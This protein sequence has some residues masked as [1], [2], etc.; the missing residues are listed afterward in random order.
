MNFRDQRL[1]CEVC[2]KSFIF[3]VTEQR[4]LSESGEAV[5]QTRCPSCRL[6]DSETGRWL[7]QIKWFSYEKGYGFIVKPNADEIF[8][9]RSQVVDEPL[10]SLE[11]G[12]Q[13]TFEQVK[14]DRGSEAQQ[15]KVVP[16]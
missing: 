5:T 8:F 9:H 12:T 7:G 15:V 11:E 14:T 4:K 3:T 16:Q 6:Q 10:V 13:V 1:T 2:G